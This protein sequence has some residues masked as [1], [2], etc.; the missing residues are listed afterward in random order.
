MVL[1][2][3]TGFVVAYHPRVNDIIRR[4]TLLPANGMQAVILV[5][6]VAM[7]LG[8]VHWGLSLILGPI[9]AREMGM[10]AHQNG[11][12]VHYPVLDVAGYMSLVVTWHWG[13][14]GSAPLLLATE[15]NDFI[16]EGVLHAVVPA[17]ETIF[18][19]YAL[20]LTVVS[21]VFAAIVLWLLTP[22]G[23][24][25]RGSTEFVS[26]EELFEPVTDGGV[27]VEERD[28]DVPAEKI[29]NSRILGGIIALTGV[30]MVAWQFVQAGLD[31]LALNVV[32]FGFLMIGL[33]I[34]LRPQG[35]WRR[36][37]DA[38]PQ[39][40]SSCCSRSSRASRG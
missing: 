1:I 37:G 36:Y 11:T 17:S 31:S 29:N 32:N 26:E 19:P 21:I 5:A 23:E 18:H 7:V 6:V 10:T 14:S 16:E 9:F 24:H 28:P 35:Y 22:T 39:R 3:M 2:L 27:E 30:V 38:V 13:L 40:G 12:N 25:A 34:F 33:L 4:L 8:R 20:M 15:G